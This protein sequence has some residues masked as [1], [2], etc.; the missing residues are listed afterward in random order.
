MSSS[1]FKG[2]GIQIAQHAVQ[3]LSFMSIFLFFGLEFCAAD[4]ADVFSRDWCA[5]R[6]LAVMRKDNNNKDLDS[7][8]ERAY[9]I[10]SSRLSDME[11][12]PETEEVF[13]ASKQP[14]H[15]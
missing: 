9:F 4:S 3:L 14:E 5:Q 8:T 6:R 1:Q 10:F 2:Q 12:L 7:F 13:S 11:L 15:V